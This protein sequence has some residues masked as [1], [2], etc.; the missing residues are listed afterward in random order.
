MQSEKLADIIARKA[1]GFKVNEPLYY[2]IAP[3]VDE[4]AREIAEEK[5]R[6]KL[7]NKE[8]SRAGLYQHLIK[9]H[10]RELVE[11]MSELK[12]FIYL[13]K[14]LNI[15]YNDLKKMIEKRDGVYVCL[16]CNKEFT[17]QGIYLHLARKHKQ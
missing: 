10:R 6:C 9:K 8:F 16:A 2:K 1:V 11:K 13:A 15:D 14:S 5:R 3:A 4:I 17:L 12:D 7:C